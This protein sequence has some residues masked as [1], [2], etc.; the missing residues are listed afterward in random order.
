MPPADSHRGLSLSLRT[1]HALHLRNPANHAPAVHVIPTSQTGTWAG[2]PQAEPGRHRGQPYSEPTP[3]SPG[4]ACPGSADRGA[5]A[6]DPQH[7]ED[8]LLLVLALSHL[9]LLSHYLSKKG[10]KMLKT[11]G[12]QELTPM[13][14]AETRRAWPPRAPVVSA[15]PLPLALP[16]ANM[17]PVPPSYSLHPATQLT[18]SLIHI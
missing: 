7:S 14:G 5:E 16:E 2:G 12:P 9:G 13:T 17:S 4:S 10:L 15:L 6:T 3:A 18:L 1:M 11:S 8:S